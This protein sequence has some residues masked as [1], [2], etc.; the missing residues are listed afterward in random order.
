MSNPSMEQKYPIKMGTRNCDIDPRDA[1]DIPT[2]SNTNNSIGPKVGS[3]FIQPM[4]SI[5]QSTANN[6]LIRPMQFE[7][8]EKSFEEKIYI[9][10]YTISNIDED[11]PASKT[12]SICIGRTMAYSDIKN[13]LQSGLEIDVHRSYVMTETKQTETKTGDIK[14]FMVPYEECMS[15]YAF[16][17]SIG[18]FY[19]DEFD[20]EDYADGDIPEDNRS[21]IVNTV[22]SSE[23]IEYRNMLEEAI[24]RDRF[25]STMRQIYGPE[26]SNN[27]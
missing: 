2:T 18:S 6:G 20:I 15:V 27:V 1:Y 5:E 3:K 23:Q 26:G 11:D 8:K 13:K 7:A 16:C 24:G 4:V 14:Y 21:G 19:S 12:F 25:I 10:F 22:L 17:T 9:L